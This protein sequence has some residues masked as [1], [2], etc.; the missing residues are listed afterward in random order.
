MS[1]EQPAGTENPVAV[2]KQL[3]KD[4]LDRRPSGMRQ[5]LALA[6]GK[7][8]SFVSQIS[9]PSYPTPIPAEHVDRIL[10][11]CHFGPEERTAFLDA[12]RAAHP[13]RLTDV[14]DSAGKR[15]L[16]LDVPDFGDAAANRA[17]DRAVVDMVKRMERLMSESR[18]GGADE[19]N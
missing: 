4:A 13:R 7:N 17:F 12:Y 2:Y 16:T 3:L 5:R 18:D 11:V 9:N 10:E 15:S 14:A 1:S 6:I 19:E 8:R